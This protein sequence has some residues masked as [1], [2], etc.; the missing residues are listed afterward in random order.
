M[1]KV[2]LA[3]GG[4]KKSPFYRVVVS[5]NRSARDSRFI[6]RIGYFNPISLNNNNHKVLYIQL[7]RFKYWLERGA[8]PSK[9]VFTL[10]KEMKKKIICD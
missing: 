6:E 1:V 10:V 2:R 5:D 3:R 4:V 7:E 8:Q 9:R